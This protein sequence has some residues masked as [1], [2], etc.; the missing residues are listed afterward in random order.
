MRRPYCTTDPVDHSANILTAPDRPPSIKPVPIDSLMRTVLIAR[1]PSVSP[2][3][4]PPT[5]TKAATNQPTNLPSPL[6]NQ[7]PEPSSSL[8]AVSNTTHSS[9]LRDPISAPAADGAEAAPRGVLLAALALTWAMGSG[10]ADR[11][12]T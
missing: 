9:T 7:H 12:P 3:A 5:A 8:P 1:Q 2:A 6:P 11:R 10:N 4:H